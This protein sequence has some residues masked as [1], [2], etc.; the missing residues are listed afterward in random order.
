MGNQGLLPLMGFGLL[1]GLSLSSVDTGARWPIAQAVLRPELRA[2]GRAALDMM[3]G[4][5]GSLAMTLSGQLV[6]FQGGNITAMLL[7]MIP[8]PKLL[9]ALL[10]AP[11]FH[12]YPSDRKKLHG[13]LLERRAELSGK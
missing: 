10:W 13:L 3:T 1:A 12:T 6:A 9:A 4:I 8:I 11:I 7:L 2:T 5:V